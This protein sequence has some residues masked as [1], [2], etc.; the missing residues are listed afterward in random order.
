M[1]ELL[2]LYF[3]FDSR[4]KLSLKILFFMFEVHR[5]I[6]KFLLII[7]KTIEKTG[8]SKYNNNDIIFNN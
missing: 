1:L 2:K 8:L 7:F 4:I 6:N 3:D 5:K